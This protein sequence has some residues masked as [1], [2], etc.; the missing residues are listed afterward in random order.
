MK[1]SSLALHTSLVSSSLHKEGL[2]DI[3]SDRHFHGRTAVSGNH[4]GK[5]S[6]IAQLLS[7]LFLGISSSVYAQDGVTGI[8]EGMIWQAN[9]DLGSSALLAD[10]KETG[11]NLQNGSTL[12]FDMRVNS[13]YENAYPARENTGVTTLLAMNSGKLVITGQPAGGENTSP[14]IGIT[15][16]NNPSYLTENRY[17]SS[18][19]TNYSVVAYGPDSEIRIKGVNLDLKGVAEGVDAV[20]GGSIVVD[21]DLVRIRADQSGLQHHAISVDKGGTVDITSKKVEL[22]VSGK[23]EEHSNPL[24]VYSAGLFQ[25]KG[26]KIRIHAAEQLSIQVDTDNL[27]RDHQN[28]GVYAL[29]QQKGTDGII[30]LSGGTFDVNVKGAPSNKGLVSLG[31]HSNSSL[32]AKFNDISIVAGDIG[33]VTTSYQTGGRRNGQVAE[34]LVNASNRLYIEAAQGIVVQSLYAEKTSAG[35]T[36]ENLQ[37]KA[38]DFALGGWSFYDAPANLE[39]SAENAVL[40]SE[41]IGVYSDV[42]Y[43]STDDA[44]FLMD[45]QG[46]KSLS[47]TAPVVAY[48]EGKGVINLND[49]SDG[50]T[51][52]T[53]GTI[54]SSASKINIGLN[55]A[56]SFWTGFSQDYRS[57]D[58]ESFIASVNVTAKD[59]ATWNVRPV[60]EDYRVNETDA[61]SYL[62]SWHSVDASNIDL[63]LAD[64]SYQAVDIGTLT[65]KNTTFRLAT[66]VDAPRG[67]GKGT[68]Q[69]IVHTG[70]GNHAIMV[71]PTGRAQA[72]E[73]ADY[74]V[75]HKEENDATSTRIVNHET[76]ETAATGVGDLSFTLANRGQAVDVGVYQYKLATRDALD[77]DGT[78]WYLKRTDKPSSSTDLVTS[79][80]A[81]VVPG[82]LWWAQL[83][84]L[85][86]RLGEVRYG[87]QDGLWA[88]AIT[89]EDESRGLAHNSFH[90]KVYGLN[91]GLDRIVRQDEKSMWLIGGN[92]KAF[93]AEQDIR[94]QA[95]GDGETDSWGLN[96]YATWADWEGYYADFVL[97]FDHY[98]QKMHTTMTDWQRVRGDYNTWG[99][100]ASIEIGRMFSSTQDDEGWGAWYSN[101]FIEPQAQ[102]AYYWVKGRDFTLDNGMQVSQ[103]DGD[104]LTGR[105]GLVLGKKY[106][107][108]KNRA[109]VDKRYAQ[110]YLEGGVKQELAGRQHVSVNDVRFSG[111]MGGTRIYYGAGFDWN[112]TDQTRLYA[113][114]E[115]ENGDRYDRD[116]YITAGIKYQY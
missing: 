31:Y 16:E 33:I 4:P 99:L 53:G 68:D 98:D 22:V 113:Q 47:I 88:R 43:H 10:G 108:G 82:T 81:V 30:N 100:G 90:Q 116:Y 27:I 50:R 32:T 51:T 44:T 71:E 42:R 85:R 5:L 64:G 95:G 62:T 14:V 59:G 24:A 2:P 45:V 104:S 112:L 12:D 17:S 49:R 86:K 80:P 91:L 107:Y 9:A 8:T 73:Q 66:D 70:S 92:L 54:A 69:A 60:Q 94:T 72:M 19:A 103:G 77:G 15:T 41:S 46:S 93:H 7:V 3:F 11:F 29:G 101:W 78:E 111:D 55:T 1:K 63:R 48:G 79:L 36:A 37:I 13:R 97:S 26:G 35:V 40:T 38:R 67:E 56:D 76:G 109:E 106:H 52:L 115:R 20:A 87:A 23:A 105:L 39:V 75:W 114:I 96:L 57:S 28:Y 102:L 84:D 18:D 89:W 83:S 65:G 34:T 61:K 110:F 58:D 25:L 6:R 74:L 21:N